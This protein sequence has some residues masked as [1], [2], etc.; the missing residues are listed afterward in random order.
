M[1]FITQ[2]SNCSLEDA[3]ILNARCVCA[4]ICAQSCPTP[5]DPMD[6]SPPGCSVRGISQARILDQVAISF[7]TDLP[8]PG[9]KLASLSSCSCISGQLVAHLGETG[10]GGLIW[11]GSSMVHV[12][13]SS[14]I[15]Q[16][17]ETG[18]HGSW[19][20]C[21]EENRAHKAFRDQTWSWDISSTAF[22]HSVLLWK[23]TRLT[24]LCVSGV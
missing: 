12:L 2:S 16:P 5:C 14:I 20:S 17:A 22:K 8:N 21:E 18:S 11:K 7:S 23:Y 15:F 24:I 6:C 19:Q 4:C 3:A 1:S 9:I 10:Q 13:S